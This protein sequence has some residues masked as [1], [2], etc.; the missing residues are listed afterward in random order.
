MD[1]VT[2]SKPTRQNRT[3]VLHLGNTLAEYQA[4][5]STNEGLQALIIRVEIA[6]SLD[7]G[8]LA[9][10]HYEGCP[11][12]LHFT[13]HATYTRYLKHF[14]GT[15][16]LV[17]IV[18]VRCLDCGAVFTILPSFV[19]RYKRYDT[20]AIEKF[21]VLLFITEDSY[22]MAGVSQTLGMD[23]QREGTWAA[24]EEAGPEAISPM[25][26]WR[27]V[28][29][30]GQLSPAQLN[31]ALGVEPPTH[32]IE[33]E[34][35]M[36]ECGEKVYA[37]IVYA[38][39]EALIWWIDYLDSVSEDALQASLERFKALSERLTHITGATV[40]GWDPAQQALRAAFPGITLAECHLHALLKLGDHLATFKRQ[41]K[42]ASRPV[43]EQE[44][45][46]IRD[47]FMRVLQAPTPEAYQK[48][49]DE[50]PAA[51][52]CEPLASRK[53][54]LTVK[55]TLFQAWTTDE[56]LA[57]VTTA[58]DQC[59]KFLNRKQENMQTFHGDKSGLAT[60]NAW[61]ITRNCWRFLKG[62]KRAGLSPLELAGADF[63]GIPWMQLVN[64]VLCAWPTLALAAG[65]LM[66]ST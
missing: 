17:S 33:D 34:K 66:G 32:I 48:A 40:D 19:V 49:L 41:R 23:A 53:D 21:M 12:R 20:D 16:S 37:P 1:S 60:L 58:L 3:V 61:A 47:A 25:A 64:L 51:F 44:E 10:G 5:L 36:T 59:M 9:D 24:L 43:S 15:W 63:L 46:Q 62:A 27:L 14:D 52:N 26:L 55:Q 31:L 4:N 56:K 45:A 6:D 42:Q 38:P 13:H 8:H 29:W 11:R 18:R 39:K 30:F 35:H 50:L 2:A 54:S 28:Q 7:W 65:A 22:R 57:V